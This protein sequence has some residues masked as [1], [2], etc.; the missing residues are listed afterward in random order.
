MKVLLQELVLVLAQ[1]LVLVLAQ[2]LEQQRQF[3]EPLQLHP[4][5]G[6]SF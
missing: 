5:L 6:N 1:E 4:L 2:G 3:V